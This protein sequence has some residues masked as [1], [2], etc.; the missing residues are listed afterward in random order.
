MEKTLKIDGKNVTFKVTGGT[1]YRYD[2]QFKKSFLADAASLSNFEE[3]KK[4]KKVKRPDG[5]ITFQDEYDFTKLNLEL[6]YNIAWTMAKTADPSIPD[7]QV[8]LDSFETF[9]I[10]EI[11]EPIMD[12]LQKSIEMNPK[13]V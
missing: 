4:K 10:T 13:N 12:M 5:K 2:Q 11:I 9:P 7:P 6:V 8:W 1:L 3:T